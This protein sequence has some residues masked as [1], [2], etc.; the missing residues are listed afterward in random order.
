MKSKLLAILFSMVL[1]LMAFSAAAADHVTVAEDAESGASLNP[2]LST[3]RND[4]W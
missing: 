1:M 2:R 3:S 4:Y